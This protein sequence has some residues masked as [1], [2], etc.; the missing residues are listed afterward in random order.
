MSKDH[1]NKRSSRNYEDWDDDIN[2]SRK[3]IKKHR[4]K[5]WDDEDDFHRESRHSHGKMRRK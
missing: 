4:K 3:K 2:F 5:S 1:S